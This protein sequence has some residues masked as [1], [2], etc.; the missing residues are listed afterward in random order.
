MIIHR[1]GVGALTVKGH[2]IPSKWF[3]A[4]SEK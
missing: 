1:I 4:R 2:T 3:H